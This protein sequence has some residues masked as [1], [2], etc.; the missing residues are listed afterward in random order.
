MPFSVHCRN[1][2]F[3]IHA[4]LVLEILGLKSLK[5]PVLAPTLVCG[6]R[7]DRGDDFSLRSPHVP[8]L[9][10]YRNVSKN[11]SLHMSKRWL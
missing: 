11:Q 4:R 10:K 1:L 5:K 2:I 7:A 8:D 6:P 9:V 3:L